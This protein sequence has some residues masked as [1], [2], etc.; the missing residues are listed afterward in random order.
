MECEFLQP[1]SLERR[2]VSSDELNAIYLLYNKCLAPVPG[3]KSCFTFAI[4]NA[5]QLPM[6][7]SFLWHAGRMLVNSKI[8]RVFPSVDL[9]MSIPE[10]CRIRYVIIR[11]LSSI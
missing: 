3:T 7:V 10:G 1:N 4:R 9:S 8:I 11:K 2:A 5:K 6:Q